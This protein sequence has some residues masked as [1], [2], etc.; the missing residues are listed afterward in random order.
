MSK[1]Q[2]PEIKPVDAAGSSA[3]LGRKR[4]RKIGLLSVISIIVVIAAVIAFNWFVDYL[5]NR[6]VLEIDMTAES[7][8][9]IS[10][11]TAQL[12]ASLKEP[13]T[14]TVLCNETDYDNDSDLRRLPKVLQ[15]YVQLSNGNVT[16][17]YVNAVAN[18]ELFSKYDNLGDL[19]T[20]DIIVESAKRYK[21]LEPHDL[22]EY[23]RS[24]SGS[25][26]ATGLRAEQR[27]TSAIL[28]VTANKIPK[29]SYIVGHNENT[30]LDTLETLLNTSNYDVD[31]IKLMQT[32]EIP[33]DVDMIIISEPKGDYTEEEIQVIDDFLEEGGRMIVSFA[34]NTPSL[35][36][37]EEY[38]EEWGVHY[39]Q[40]I[41]Y[42]PAL[43]F[44]G[45]PMAILP[46]VETV[47]NLTDNLSR[48]SSVVVVNP[49]PVSVLWA[50]DNW[51]GTQPLL[52]TSSAA[53]A[54]D[55]GSV[56]N[57]Y[58]QSAEDVTGP[59][60]VGVLSYQSKMHNLNA[61][62]SYVLFLNAGFISDTTLGNGSF[63]NQDYMLAALN[64]MS[65]DSEAVVINSKNLESAALVITGSTRRVLF[66]TLI[67]IPFVILLAGIV[68]WVRRRH[69]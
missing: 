36:H 41:V 14:I 22:L 8:Y 63:M 21:A 69:K 1:N 60:N 58:E 48:D 26:Y 27:L 5:A 15:R 68:V 33:S 13:V 3:E 32:A 9:E 30:N 34:V 11:D 44:A 7:E 17:N 31:T 42:D 10:E 35:P 39:E 4:R 51:K 25:Y 46:Q 67:A 52:T 12:L 37:L 43:C 57:A 19:S 66:Y 18:P 47:E 2:K 28:Y 59:F 61:T 55:T 24:D 23:T 6:Y 40:S 45:N 62:M 49:R 20:G 56:T 65:D 50:N 29:A 53:Y 16:L 54:K 64:F 38:F